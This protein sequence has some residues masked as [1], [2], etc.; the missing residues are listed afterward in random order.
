LDCYS[1]HPTTN[2]AVF[3]E[4]VHHGARHI[5]RN[6]K[7]DTDVASRRRQNLRVNADQVAVCVYQCA[8]RITTIDCCIGL[9]EVLKTAVAESCRAT[10]GANDAR[11]DGLSYSKRISNRKNYI[12]DAN[13]IRVAQGDGWQISGVDFQYRE[14]TRWI[15]TYEFGSECTVVSQL[16][17]DFERTI[18]NMVVSKNV[19]LGIDDHSRS[20]S[21][22]SA[23]RLGKTIAKE[24]SKCWVVHEGILRRGPRAF[25][26][27]NRHDGRG[28]LAHDVRI[29]TRRGLSTNRCDGKY[30]QK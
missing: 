20:N 7:A 28:H 30:H 9:K 8:A 11:G 29:R 15:R 5:R 17:L 14:I 21:L 13:T 26:R 3:Q 19:T 23:R 22:R 1:K 18:D 25:S 10:F 27:S 16:N 6:R 24:L 2:F 12:A 4:L